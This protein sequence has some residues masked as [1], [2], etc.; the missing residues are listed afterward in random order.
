MNLKH[1]PHRPD[2]KPQSGYRLLNMDELP[3]P[4]D[5]AKIGKRGEWLPVEQG[6]WKKSPFETPMNENCVPVRR[7]LP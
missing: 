3:L 4:G 6:R 7:K 5:E 1:D 2:I